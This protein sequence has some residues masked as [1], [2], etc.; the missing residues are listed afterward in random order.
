MV[1]MTTFPKTPRLDFTS[2]QLPSLSGHVVISIFN[3]M[4]LKIAP[5]TT[6]RPEPVVPYVPSRV[7]LMFAL[8]RSKSSGAVASGEGWRFLYIVC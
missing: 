6:Q 4:R 3:R 5:T 2:I 8:I 1:S 7:T